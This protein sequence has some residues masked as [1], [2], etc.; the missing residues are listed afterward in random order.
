MPASHESPAPTP[1]PASEDPE[2]ERPPHHASGGGFRN[3]W[4]APDIRGGRD[5]LKWMA[6]RV[7]SGRIFE[8]ER[9]SFQIATPSFDR[10]RAARDTLTATWVG[11][12]TVLVQLGTVTVLTDPIWSRRASP[13]PLLGPSRHVRAAVPFAEL[14][15]IDVTLVS[16]NHYDHLDARTVRRLRRRLPDMPWAAPLGLASWL[17]ARGVR[18]A[19]E[20]DWWDTLHVGGAQ[21]TPV[22]ARHF[23]A[24]G[25]D[26][27]FATLWCGWVIEADGWRVLFCG[28]SG[29]HDDWAEIGARLGPFDLMMIPIGA[30]EPRWFMAPVHMNPEEAVATY[31]AVIAGGAPPA[32]NVPP[33]RH[34]PVMLPIHWGTFKLTDE[35]L[36]Q[37][38]ARVRAAW[39]SAGHDS[40]SL[41][42]LRHGE[43]RRIERGA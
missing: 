6:Q 20:L 26:D 16:H 22:P 32:G 42:L 18:R 10:P 33:T 21:V 25:L 14:P 29:M 39:A 28:D 11:H 4:H 7:T 43:T 3:P 8:R 17:R 30:Y 36:D 13:V 35:P 1:S 9:A 12:S 40:Q 38:P 31:E 27:R 5:V 34:P 23:S 2:R 41:W 24:R 15:P 37:P 19:W